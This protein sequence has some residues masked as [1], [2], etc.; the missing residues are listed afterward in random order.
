[1]ALTET[2]EHL[3]TLLK[4]IGID[5]DTTQ[6][7]C[8]NLSEEEQIQMGKFIQ[9]RYREK[10]EVTEEEILKVLMNLIKIRQ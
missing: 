6:M 1:M 7:V 3:I 2:A 10:G 4:G 5:L 9:Q 8:A